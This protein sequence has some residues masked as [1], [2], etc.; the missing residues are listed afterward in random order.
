MFTS[1][2]LVKNFFITVEYHIKIWLFWAG[3]FLPVF[4]LGFL[5]WVYPKKTQSYVPGCP[6]P[7]RGVFAPSFLPSLL[8]SIFSFHFSSLYLFLSRHW[9]LG[10]HCWLCSGVR[11]RATAKNAFLVYF[12]PISGQFWVFD[13][14]EIWQGVEDQ[15]LHWLGYI[16]GFLTPN[17]KS[18]I[19]LTYSL[20]RVSP[21]LDI[22]KI[23]ML[24]LPVWSASVF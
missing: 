3:V 7:A 4:L 18:R 13:Y 22:H 5:K 2:N 24:Y 15:I 8:F 10:E 11:N 16:L 19:L 17:R 9:D 23:C 12:E 1:F 20:C 14:H 6:N 21:L